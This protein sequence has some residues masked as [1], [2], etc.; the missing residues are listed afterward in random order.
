MQRNSQRKARNRLSLSPA[1]RIG[2]EQAKFG[3][4]LDP[5]R[6]QISSASQQAGATERGTNPGTARFGGIHR[7]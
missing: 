6:P 7:N 3:C 5:N 2:P 1:P 4:E